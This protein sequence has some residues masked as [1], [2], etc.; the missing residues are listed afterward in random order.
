MKAGTIGT[1]ADWY[2]VV[3]L[4]RR[5]FGLPIPHTAII[6]QNQQ[7]IAESLGNFVEQNFLTPEIVIGKL[8]DHNA[9]KAVAN[10]LV[11][12]ANSRAIAESVAHSIPGLLNGLDDADA[13]RFFER[14]AIPQLRTLDVSRLAGNILEI[15]TEGNR[16]QPFLDRGLQ[17]LERW[18]TANAGLL[19]A[20]FSEASRYTPAQ[21][22]AYIVDKFVGGIVVLLHEVVAN[23]DHE[24]RLQFDR[25]MQDLVVE[26]QTSRGYRRIGKAWMRDCIRHLRKGDYY[27]ALWD[28]I[29]TR[30]KAEVDRENS[31]VHSVTASVLVSLGKGLRDEPAIQNKL[32]TWWLDLAH[33]V[34]RRYRHQISAL[35]TEVV[36]SWD[37]EEVS[38]KIE[39]E[40]GRDLQYIR[41]NG[42]FIGGAVGV[43][44]HAAVLLVVP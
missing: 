32:N 18:L 8:R 22:D 41:I 19:K 40:I 9:A 7:R 23:P 39:N 27:R 11:H 37:P 20:K 13:A 28:H 30:V 14:T 4:F 12:P 15:V 17:A 34:V 21:L 5:P 25:A 16:H 35:I 6:A 1:I 43:L 24:L 26:L 36:K 2:A 42:T 44:L 10:W 33:T 38:Q 3:A 29:R 31:L